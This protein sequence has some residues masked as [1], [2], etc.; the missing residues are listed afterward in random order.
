MPQKATKGNKAKMYMK[1]YCRHLPCLFA[2][3]VLLLSGAGCTKAAKVRRLLESADRDYKA[4]QYDAAELKYRGV[5][6]LSYLNP[7]AVRQLGLLYVTEGRPAQ[8]APFLNKAL[9]QNPDD[10]ELQVRMAQTLEALGSV[11]NAYRVASKVLDKEATN[12]DALLLCADVA[13]SSTNLAIVRKRIEESQGVAPDVAAFHV[14]LAWMDLRTEQT[15][16]ADAEIQKALKLDPKDAFAYRAKSALELLSKDR[17]A[18]ANDFKTA[19][20]LSPLRS[21]MRVKYADF[22]FEIGATNDA[23]H[24][25]EDLTRQVP[26]YFPGWLNLMSLFYAERNYDQCSEVITKVLARDSLNFDALMQSGELSM[27]KHDGTNA[28]T[29]FQL[30]DSTHKNRPEVKCR[31]AMAYLMNGQRANAVSRLNEALALDHNYAPATLMLAELDV[32]SGESANAIKLLVPLAKKIPNDAKVHLLLAT[33][34]LAERQPDAALDVYRQMEEIFPKNPEVPRLMGVVYEQEGNGA[35]ARDTFEKSLVLAPDYLPTLERITGL[36]MSANHYDAAEERLAAVISRNPKQA[37][38]WLLQGKVYEAAGKTNQAESAMSKAIE[39][40]PDLP[41]PYLSLATLYL[42][43]HQDQQAL[44]RLNALVSKTNNI[45][46]MFEIG[47]IHQ[48]ANR[49]DEARKAY[50]KLLAIAPDFSPAL[51]NLAYLYSEH[52][53]NLDKAMQMAERARRVHPDDPHVADTLAWILYKQGQYPRAL[54]LLQESLERIPNSAEVQMHL[55]MTYYMMEEEDLA[56]VHLQ[57]ALSVGADYPGKDDARQCM[58][59]LAIDPATAT[60]ADIDVLEKR[61]HDD[62]HDPVPLSRLAAIDERHGEVEKAVDAYQKLI[63]QNPQDWKAMIKLGRLY[64]G[65]LHQTRQALDLAKT[66]HDLAPND[67]RAEAMLGGLVYD[68][69]DYP[70][71]LS[72]LQESAPRLADQPAVQYDLALAYYAAGR[73]DQADD[74]MNEALKAGGALPT[75]DQAKQFQAYRAAAKDPAASAISAGQIKAVL[76]KNPHYLPALA[77]SGILSERQGD[78]AQA[79]KTYE[80]ILSEYPQFA[81]ALR[82]LVFIY[83]QH[84]GDESKAYELGEKARAAYPDDLDLAKALGILAY[85]KGDYQ[86]SLQ[87]LRDSSRKFGNDGELLYYLGM[88]YYQLKQSAESK[89]TLQR[90]VSLN[91]PSPLA[92]EAKRVLAELK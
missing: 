88:D 45:M 32:R 31:L 22:Q 2:L 72:L 83:S 81:P 63:A 66:A 53:G 54:G 70:W 59:L 71:A 37:E 42:R 90:S 46:A 91:L 80:Q 26:D 33:A 57:Q 20:D 82:Q 75:L 44:D 21:T 76:D 27:V 52:F 8:A 35:K 17:Q 24:L 78:T 6:R 68:S 43:T 58:A 34:Y 60:P 28:I 1:R 15:N 61:L 25:L 50:E 18:A 55:G 64:S 5:L 29:T 4:E 13:H 62:P 74:A 12:E 38:P 73:L 9:Q 77:L 7:T 69:G 3:A 10:L 47:E 86:R 79:A 84:S 49:M 51:N 30:V 87:L 67:P 41:G 92:S 89:R 48:Q 19:A 56:R 40:D 11:A 65:S 85:R 14:A 16:A 39:L 36:D 23:V